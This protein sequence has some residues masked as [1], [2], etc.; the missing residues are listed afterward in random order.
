[1]KSY[2]ISFLYC[3][4][5]MWQGVGYAEQYIPPRLPE[6]MVFDLILPLGM[7]KNTTEINTLFQYSFTENAAEYNPEIEHT[8][9]DG[10]A[11]ELEFPIRNTTLEAY[12]LALQGTFSFPY[13][14]NFV[15]GWQ[16]IAEYHRH[17]KSFE[18]DILYLFGY[19]FDEN[20]SMLNMVG[21]HATDVRSRGHIDGLVNSNLFY[22]VLPQITVGVE[23]NWVSRSNRADHLL[24]M[25]QLHVALAKFSTLQLGFGISREGNQDSAHGASRLIFVF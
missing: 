5:S 13:R 12:K 18:N 6:P 8:F 3:L 22:K 9:L 17:S 2:E 20:W 10:Y 14:S 11:I 1:M 16:Y 24:V 23:V 7:P 4:L 19:Q 21:I 25:P 15:H